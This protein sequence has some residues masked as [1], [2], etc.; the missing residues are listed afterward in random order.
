METVVTRRKLLVIAQGGAAAIA[1]GGCAVMRGGAS[2]PVVE[3]NKEQLAAQ[4]GSSAL[5]VL[6]LGGL[7]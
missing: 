6:G 1:F 2:H 5:T 3:A 4:A 7:S